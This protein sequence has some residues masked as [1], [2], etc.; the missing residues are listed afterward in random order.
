MKLVCTLEARAKPVRQLAEL[1]RT[2]RDQYPGDW[3]IFAVAATP[4]GGNDLKP[5]VRDAGF[6]SG[7]AASRKCHCHDCAS[8]VYHRNNEENK[9]RVRDSH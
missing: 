8:L 7:R 9:T 4:M 3:E 1:E 5:L 6:T 2:L